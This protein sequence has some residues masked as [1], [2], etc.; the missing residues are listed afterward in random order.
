[1]AIRILSM[2][3]GSAHQRRCRGLLAIGIIL[4][5]ASPAAADRHACQTV[6]RVYDGDTVLVSTDTGKRLI[7]LLGIDAPETSKTRGQ[8]GQP[9]SSRARRYLTRRIQDR[10]VQLKSYGTD[11]YNRIL[12]VITLEGVDINLEMVVQGLAE[13][14]RGRPPEGF[15]RRPYR[16]AQ[17][18]ARRERRGMWIQEAAYRSPMEWKHGR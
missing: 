16:R 13:V 7:R 4:L 3:P 11:R 17:E 2:I 9:F 10:C 6:L 1:M 14:Y 8:T 5:L 18:T 15:D 12:A